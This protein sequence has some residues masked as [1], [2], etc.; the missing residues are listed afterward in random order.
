M[1]HFDSK[2]L[3]TLCH[4]FNIHVTSSRHHWLILLNGCDIVSNLGDKSRTCVMGPR[5]LWIQPNT[6]PQR[7][8]F[9]RK[10]GGLPR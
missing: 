5:S 10:I 7:L 1:L 3:S 9:V 4:L 6:M 2:I 8:H